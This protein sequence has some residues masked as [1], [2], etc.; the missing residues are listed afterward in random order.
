MLRSS[1][2]LNATSSKAAKRRAEAKPIRDA[3]V[4]KHGQCMICGARPGARNGRLP[5]Q[6]QIC[7]HE[8]LNGPMRQKAMDKPYA[9]LVVCWH[10]N[11]ELNCKGEWPVERQLAV[12]QANSPEDYDLVAINYLSNPK[13]PE[14]WTQDDVDRYD[15]QRPYAIR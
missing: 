1:K 13:A 2:R 10:C 12:L 15:H 11:G 4:A 14:R 3:L 6:N 8:I 7:V 9:T 5:E